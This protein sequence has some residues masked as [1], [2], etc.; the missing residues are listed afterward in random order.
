MCFVFLQV[1]QPSPKQIFMNMFK[2]SCGKM[3]NLT[4]FPLGFLFVC[5]FLF[6]FYSY[7]LFEEK[8]LNVSGDVFYSVHIN[9]LNYGAYWE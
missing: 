8:K 7:A 5:L 1:H 2:L 6:L 9:G 4:V 3:I